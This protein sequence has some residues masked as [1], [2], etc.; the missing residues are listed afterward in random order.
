MDEIE[1]DTEDWSGVKVVLT[2]TFISSAAFCFVFEFARRLDLVKEVFD[3]RRKVR[4]NHTPPPLIQQRYF[5]WWF[6]STEPGYTEYAKMQNERILQERK[7]SDI[8]SLKISHYINNILSQ[9]E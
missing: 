6:L 3:M 5:E 4:P 7:S 9:I 8:V 1:S 2:S